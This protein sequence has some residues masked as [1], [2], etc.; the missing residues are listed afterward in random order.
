M[1]ESSPI[2][3]VY[4]LGALCLWSTSPF[5]FLA[6]S[7]HVSAFTTNLT[8]LLLATLF[9]IAGCTAQSAWLGVWPAALIPGF[10][11]SL[12]LALSGVAALA[13]GDH[14]MY[15]SL[16]TAGPERT[17][18]ILLLSPAI[19]A[20]LAWIS[21]GETLSSAQILGMVLVLAGVA[22]TIWKTGKAEKSGVS[23]HVIRDSI[24]SAAC[25]GVGSMLARQAFFIEPSVNPLV[26]TAIRVGS[27][28]LVLLIAAR[29][30]GSLNS[31]LRSVRPPMVAKNL[32]GGVLT[33]PVL[34][35]LFFITAMKFQP[36]GI[37]T[38]ITFMSP[39]LIIPIGMIRFG[40]R[41][42]LKTLGG[43]AVALGG[44]ILLGLNS[45]S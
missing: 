39:L 6:M 15:R 21:M 19:T 24:A 37:V 12:Y 36:A 43:G 23:P 20:A 22:L 13:V 45:R 2:G 9:L 31:A 35:M 5:F 28:A 14:F 16:F 7:R 38:T 4:A 10:K 29:Y 44:V 34:G 18:L 32:L 8:R 17:A 11:A 41:L 26:G 1:S 42:D 40:T 3:L 25:L 27:G 30:R 33:G